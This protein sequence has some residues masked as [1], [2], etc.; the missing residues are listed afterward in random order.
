M[1]TQYYSVVLNLNSSIIIS[2][3]Y[4]MFCF[5][6][7]KEQS[8]DEKESSEKEKPNKESTSNETKTEQS[9]KPA[10]TKPEGEQ[11]TEDDEDADQPPRNIDAV[12]LLFDLEAAEL[13]PVVIKYV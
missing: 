7:T 10:N 8:A 1:T 6:S 12:E 13:L 3:S 2:L 9:E 11:E 5:L 4:L